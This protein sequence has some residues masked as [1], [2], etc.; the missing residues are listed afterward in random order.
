MDYARKL[1]RLQHLRSLSGEGDG[2]EDRQEISA[3]YGEVAEVYESVVG[4]QRIRAAGQ[5]E[6]NS[7]P[8]SVRG[9]FPVRPHVSHARRAAGARESDRC[10]SWKA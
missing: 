6:R 2:S 4:R 10:Y 8:Q 7:I 9:G 3:V 1:E 5:Q